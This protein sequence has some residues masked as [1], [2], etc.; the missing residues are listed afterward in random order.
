MWKF[1]FENSDHDFSVKFEMNETPDTNDQIALRKNGYENQNRVILRF[2][3]LAPCI[4]NVVDM[5]SQKRGRFYFIYLSSL[6][7]IKT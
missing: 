1:D 7:T 2:A 6:T 3:Q 4:Q 5:P